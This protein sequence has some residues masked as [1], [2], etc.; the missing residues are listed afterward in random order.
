MFTLYVARSQA[1]A[2]EVQAQARQEAIA[3]ARREAQRIADGL[4]VRLGHPIAFSE[5]GGAPPV[6]PM[7][8]FA[9]EMGG[10]GFDAPA[11]ERGTNDIASHVSVT[12]EFE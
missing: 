12:Y 2:A 5:S 6:Y 3:Q 4:G 9:S 10:G 11:I 1:S 7:R 8:A